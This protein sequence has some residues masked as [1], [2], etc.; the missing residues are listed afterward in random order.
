MHSTVEEWARRYKAMAP[1]AA[2]TVAAAPPTLLLLAHLG[3]MLAEKAWRRLR[4]PQ[5]NSAECTAGVGD[6][7]A[8]TLLN[9]LRSA[10][11]TR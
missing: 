5:M 9:Y 1:E 11:I 7:H 2:E 6:F 3:A 4:L 10:S 8:E